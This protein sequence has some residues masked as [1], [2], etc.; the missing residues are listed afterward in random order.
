MNLGGKY[1]LISLNIIITV[2]SI[3]FTYIVY[4][5]YKS[6]QLHK[7]EKQIEK[8]LLRNQNIIQNTFI[9]IKSEIDGDRTLFY[10]IHSHY[11]DV[12]RLDPSLDIKR[13]KEEILQNYPLEKRD[14]DLFLL[15]NTYVITDATYKADIGFNLSL[16]PDARVELEAAQDLKVHQSPSVSID[17][18]NSQ[19]K[20]YSYSKI[21]DLL[22][23]EMG[24]INKK[25]HNILYDAMQKIH[26]LTNKQSNLYRIEQKLDNS[27]YYDNVLNKD[28]NLTKEEYL[29]AKKKFYKGSVTK[30]LVILANRNGKIYEKKV[31]GYRVFY[32]PIIKKHNMYL[33][34]MGD[35][36]L[37]LWIDTSYEKQLNEKIKTYFYLFLVFHIFFLLTIFY[38]TKRYHETQEKLNIQVKQ[39]EEL[40]DE[41]SN[42]IKFMSEQ[43]Q[44]P[45]S[46]IFTNFSMIENSLKNDYIEY[47]RHV[48][49]ALGMLLNSYE[50]L[51]YLVERKKKHYPLQKIRIDLFLE[52]RV[53]FFEDIAKTHNRTIVSE[54]S[55]NI[56]GVFN[57]VELERLIDNNLS[58]AIKYAQAGTRILVKLTADEV[59]GYISFYSFGAEIQDKQKIFQRNFQEKKLTNK[60]L[61]LGLS[62]VESICKK[63]RISIELF[64][65]NN[66][67]VFVY[68]FRHKR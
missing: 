19:I 51:H 67:N 58:N 64:Y 34:L 65:E 13:L 23:F 63:Y 66:Q 46:V 9:K 11:T 36:V 14:V 2:L 26:F 38:F 10:K 57:E 4:E 53:A 20:S 43:I 45:L 6:S 21:N 59:Y 30:D 47:R 44:T 48:K 50:D 60:S 33:E 49:A 1:Q 29:N 37:E 12:L 61:G 22:Y 24:F 15:D 39:E 56:Y 62:M 52:Q 68:R 31:D 55:Q 16:V 28:T 8:A 35:F 3:Y 18:I 7:V 54:I 42:F 17:I 41:N 40:L 25:I 5:E 32:I 27:E